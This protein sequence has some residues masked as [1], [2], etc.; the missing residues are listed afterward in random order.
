MKSHFLKASIALASAIMMLLAFTSVALALPPAH[1]HGSSVNAK[2]YGTSRNSSTCRKH[3]DGISDS[4]ASVNSVM[5]G[6]L[7]NSATTYKAVVY[8]PQ[9]V[10]RPYRVR[11]GNRALVTPSQ[12]TLRKGSSGSAVQTLQDALYSK[13]FLGLNDIDGSF[14]TTTEK[15]VIN[16]QTQTLGAKSADGVVGSVTW[17]RLFA[18]S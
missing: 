17:G 10:T 18:Q 8:S 1:N 12:S 6:C 13:G 7:A 14:G 15:A 4:T 3:C 11:M 16:F 5:N 2:G 9:G